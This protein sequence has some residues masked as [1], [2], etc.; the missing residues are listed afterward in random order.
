MVQVEKT[1]EKG[2]DVN[3]AA[4]LVYDNC[5]KDADESIVISNDSDLANA[6]GLVTNNLKCPV[7]VV[8]PNTTRNVRNNPKHCSLQRDLQ[9]VSTKCVASINDNILS[10]SQF[11]ITMTDAQGTFTK[12]ASW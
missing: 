11:P 10:K 7:T 3:L 12:P 1:E 2:S 6:I 8:N 9:K 5:M 4:Y